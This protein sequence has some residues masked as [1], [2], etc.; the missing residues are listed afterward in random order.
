MLGCN[1]FR[2]HLVEGGNSDCCR[3]Q[4]MYLQIRVQ[5]H[6]VESSYRKQTGA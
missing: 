1:V 3:E 2:R 4:C 6:I 5:T